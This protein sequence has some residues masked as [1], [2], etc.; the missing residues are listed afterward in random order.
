MLTCKM[1]KRNSVITIPTI[2]ISI[3]WLFGQ[4]L[5][6][7]GFKNLDPRYPRT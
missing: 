7:N 1:Y 5:S 6:Y 2:G 3:K 4:A